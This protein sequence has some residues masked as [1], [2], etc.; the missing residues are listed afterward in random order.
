[1]GGGR[2]E[3]SSQGSPALQHWR[4]EP[5]ARP[6][7][8][9]GKRA[10]RGRP[11]PAIGSKNLSCS[12][13]RPC[14]RPLIRLLQAPAESRHT[15]FNLVAQT[16][17]DGSSPT[18]ACRSPSLASSAF[19]TCFCQRPTSSSTADSRADSTSREHSGTLLPPMLPSP[20]RPL[21]ATLGPPPRI[22]VRQRPHI[23]PP[24]Q[25]SWHGMGDS[26]GPNCH[27][28]SFWPARSEPGL[29]PM[30]SQTVLQAMPVC[31][32]R[33]RRSHL[34]VRL[35]RDAHNIRERLH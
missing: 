29:G 18:L 26:G 32:A 19:P 25:G 24:T 12:R 21:P 33:T 35:P 30:R 31:L 28:N 22:W 13:S 7:D 34:A 5:A 15:T 11:A 16:P 2:G 23:R 27:S 10:R 9:E 17:V 3:Q 1:M 14:S 4:P 6:R 8:G 20:F